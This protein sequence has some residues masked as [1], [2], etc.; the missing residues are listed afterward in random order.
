MGEFLNKSKPSKLIE[1][2][3]L[4]H[5]SNQN[6]HKSLIKVSQMNAQTRIPKSKETCLPRCIDY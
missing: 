6:E 5:S 2:K 3:K 4:K 1:D